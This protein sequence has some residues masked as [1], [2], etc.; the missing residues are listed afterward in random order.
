MLPTN[1]PWSFLQADLAAYSTSA[2]V[3]DA[4]FDFRVCTNVT[5]T[6]IISILEQY[7]KECKVSTG[8]ITSRSY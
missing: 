4:A 1:K 7:C 5:L 8:R 2:C 6:K 3:G